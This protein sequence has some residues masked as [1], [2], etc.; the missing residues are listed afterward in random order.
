MSAGDALWRHVLAVYAR[1]EVRQA[2]LDLQDRRGANVCLLLF[3]QW[4][5]AACGHRLGRAEAERLGAA[6]PWHSEIVEGL[7][8]VRRRLRSGPAPAPDAATERL[9]AQVQAAEIEAERIEL[10]TLAALLPLSP[11]AAAET[12]AEAVALANLTLVCPP[13]TPED[14]R[15][16]EILAGS[17]P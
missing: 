13:E 8:A 3:A 9:R 5:G 1:P 2:C 17:R 11:R 7:R 14:A 12:E 6:A 16:L 10:L 4:A 15:A